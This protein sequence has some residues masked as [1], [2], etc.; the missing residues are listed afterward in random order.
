MKITKSISVDELEEKKEAA[1]EAAEMKEG[2]IIRILSVKFNKVG[3][4]IDFEKA[5]TRP[6]P[7]KDGELELRTF[8]NKGKEKF[9]YMPH[10]DL[11]IAFDLFRAHLMI[12]TQER[13]AYD[14]YGEVISPQTLDNIE[15]DESPLANVKVYGFN[16]SSG[17][18]IEIFGS[19]LIRGK[20]VKPLATPPTFFDGYD[21]EHYEFGD[22]LAH[23]AKHAVDEVLLYYHGKYAQDAQM[24]LDFNEDTDQ[25]ENF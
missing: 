9:A 15:E 12:I 23:V 5:V 14:S 11:R 24:S 25:E 10:E 17:Y 1:A 3:L 16:V 6:F 22:E 4:D 19:R 21:E 2:T 13:E 18:S 20:H 7:N 8:I